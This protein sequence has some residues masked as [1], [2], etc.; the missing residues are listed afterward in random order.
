MIRLI[1]IAAGMVLWFALAGLVFLETGV[2]AKDF[3][4]WMLIALAAPP[5][6]A[7]SAFLGRSIDS[8]SRGP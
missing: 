7:I 5:S 1:R 4:L 8:S 6:L 2:S 3:S